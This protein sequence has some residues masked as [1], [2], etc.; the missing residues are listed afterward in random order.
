MPKIKFY[1]HS[2]S[3]SAYTDPPQ[4]ASKFVPEWYRKQK[5][6]VNDAETLPKGYSTSTVKRC[7]PVFDIMTAGYMITMPCDVYL[8]STNP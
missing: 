1:Q 3:T 4:P 5:G 2:E 6:T 8:D 7:M